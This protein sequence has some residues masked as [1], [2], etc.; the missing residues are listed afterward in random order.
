MLFDINPESYG[1]AV[2]PKE[3]Y[4]YVEVWKAI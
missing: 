2:E 3:S 1:P 4:I